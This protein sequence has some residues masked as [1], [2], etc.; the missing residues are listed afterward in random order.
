MNTSK[1]VENQHLMGALFRKGNRKQRENSRRKTEREK[2]VLRNHI[3]ILNCVC[4]NGL[5]KYVF[6]ACWFFFKIKDIF[7][8]GQCIFTYLYTTLGTCLKNDVVKFCP[9]VEPAHISLNSHLPSL[10]VFWHQTEFVLTFQFSLHPWV[11]PLTCLG[12]AESKQTL[13]KRH[14]IQCPQLQVK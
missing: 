10:N 12:W 11:Y 6:F 7:L 3:E 2:T 14:L 4:S 5:C 13:V 8:F 1:Q 9:A